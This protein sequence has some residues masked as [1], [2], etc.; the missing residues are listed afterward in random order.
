MCGI[1]FAGEGEGWVDVLCEGR[2]ALPLLVLSAAA[3][4]V[5]LCVEQLTFE[6]SGNELTVNTRCV[7]SVHATATR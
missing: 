4:C 6:V 7:D 3:E 1:G 2:Y 5:V